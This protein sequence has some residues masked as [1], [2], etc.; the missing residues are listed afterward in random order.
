MTPDHLFVEL[1]KRLH[2]RKTFECGAPELNIFIQQYAQ[3]HRE[4]GISKTMVLPSM[5]QNENGASAICAFYT[6][7]HTEIARETLSAQDAKKLPHY[8]IPVML[9]AQLAIH[10][11]MQGQGM[12]KVTLI[13][14]LR[15]CLE[16]NVHLPSYAVVVDAL[17]DGVQHF[18]EQYGFK[19]LDRHDGRVRLYIPMGTVARLFQ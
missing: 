10:S 12:G 8:P 18:Y 7:S 2:D 16:I 14:A 5:E 1:D 4:A 17:N 19:L 11:Q 3:R 15:H 13:R 6:L 9:I